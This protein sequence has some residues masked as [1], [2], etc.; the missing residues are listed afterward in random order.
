M[1]RRLA[2]VAAIIVL[3]ALPAGAFNYHYGI[4]GDTNPFDHNNNWAPITYPYNIGNL[5]SPGLFG[6]GGEKFDLE[7]LSVKE[8]NSFIYVALTNSF[9]FTA[10]SSGWGTSYDLGD[11]FIYNGSQ[12]FAIDMRDGGSNESST[13]LLE[14]SSATGVPVAPGTYGGTS[15]GALAGDYQASS[16][17]ALGG[18]TY[19]KNFWQGLETN[20]MQGNG[21]SYVWEFRFDKSLIGEYSNLNFHVALGCGNDVMNESYSPVPEPAT[22]LLFGLGLLGAGALSRFRS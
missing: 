17:S 22:L 18:V 14:V 5:P 4:F 19:V 13:Q 10:T 9:G 20:P 8:D 21:D 15:W 2:A 1:I 12:T 7:G 11:L 16:Y 3:T 6:E